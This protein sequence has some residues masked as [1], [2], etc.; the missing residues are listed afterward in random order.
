M[1]TRVLA[2][3]KAT[4]IGGHNAVKAPKIRDYTGIGDSKLRA[5]V[6][7]LRTEGHPICSDSRGYFYAQSSD[8]V[9]QSIRSLSNRADNIGL[10]I[11]G[12]I[13]AFLKMNPPIIYK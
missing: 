11:D 8:E 12:L 7:Q 2:L 5:I 13:Q 6:N 4:A 3:L 10:A 9:K 1:K